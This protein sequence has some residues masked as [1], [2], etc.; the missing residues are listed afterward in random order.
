MAALIL[1]CCGATDDEIVLDYA[2]SDG[3]DQ[4]ALG[5]R[6]NMKETQGM[7]KHLFASAPPEVMREVL[8]YA[9]EQYGGLT[10][11]MTSIGFTNDK[12]ETLA[13]ALSPETKW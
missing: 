4:V 8:N 13:A 12:Q 5:G 9:G 1:A 6:E 10:A 7:D 11:Y 3:V 2:K